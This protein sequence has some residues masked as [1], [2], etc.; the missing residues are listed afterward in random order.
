MLAR[1][2]YRREPRVIAQRVLPL[3]TNT[4]AVLLL[5]HDGRG[6]V[7]QGHVE[8]LFQAAARIL[9]KPSRDSLL[10]DSFMKRDPW[11]FEVGDVSLSAH[12]RPYHDG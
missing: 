2:R 3:A 9:F 8:S 7:G 12:W 1:R 5:E 4:R 6:E 11:S 10:R